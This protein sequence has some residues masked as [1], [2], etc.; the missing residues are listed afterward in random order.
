MRRLLPALLAASLAAGLGP[1]PADAE[2]EPWDTSAAIVG[3]S[4]T[5][6]S[7]SYFP[8][9][10][11]VNGFGFRTM[12]GSA[13]RVADA[14]VGRGRIV[15]ALGTNDVSVV[16]A[17]PEITDPEAYWLGSIRAIKVALNR[18]GSDAC[19][20]WVTVR[21]TG[22]TYGEEWHALARRFNVLLRARTLHAVNW[23]WHA[24]EGA[25]DPAWFEPDGLHLTQ[26]GRQEYARF[27]RTR[28]LRMCRGAPAG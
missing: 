20:V 15:T 21:D 4:L 27:I 9:N 19:R 25:A 13:Q 17:D 14:A 28:S 8:A 3:D 23:S 1:P 10:W 26:A 2:T 5:A 16:Q 24:R 6:D 12:E 22:T 11:F 7:A 18:S